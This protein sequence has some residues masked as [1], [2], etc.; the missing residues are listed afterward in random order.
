LK[1]KYRK[2]IKD[3][4]NK[5]IDDFSNKLSEKAKRI[6]KNNGINPMPLYKNGVCMPRIINFINKTQKHYGD[7]LDYIDWEEIA[8]EII[9]KYYEQQEFLENREN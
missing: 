4:T 3:I 6:K 8:C 7:S 1:N 5:Q 9:A 2:S